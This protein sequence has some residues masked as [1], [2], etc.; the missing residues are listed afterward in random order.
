MI[1][2]D[3]WPHPEVAEDICPLRRE[4]LTAD[5]VTRKHAPLDE[6]HP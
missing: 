5:L 3:L 4:K 6:D 1:R 2:L